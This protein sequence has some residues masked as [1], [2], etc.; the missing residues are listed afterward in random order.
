MWKFI[1]FE[2]KYWIKRP[3]VWIFLVI[4]TLL[5]FFA[6]ASEN[7]TIGGGIGNIY[8][9]APYVIQQYYMVLSIIC[10]LMTTSFMNATANRD[11]QYGMYQFV[12]SSPIKKRDY[13]FGK[14]FGAA[15][16]A[17]IPLLGVSLG[18]ILGSIFA[19]IF[20]MTPAER[21]G[22]ISWAG[23][24][25]GIVNFGLPNII[26]SGVLLFSLAIIYRNTIISFIGSMLILVF[27]IVSGIFTEDIKKEWLANILDP[28]GGRP[29]ST[30]TKYLTV[31]EKNLIA[32]PLQGDLLINR[33][34]WLAIML[35]ILY[36]VYLK[37]SFSTKKES[38][39][40]VKKVKQSAP[41]IVSNQVFQ[42]TKSGVFSF[43]TLI[44][45]IKF[46]L[47]AIIKNPTFIIIVAIGMILL[48]TNLTSFSSGYGVV[49]YPVTYQVIDII[50][51][52]FALFMVG[53]IIFYT[54]VLVW[55]ERDAKINEIQDATPIQTISLFS[56][57]VIA[58]IISMAIVLLVTIIVSVIAQTLHGYYRYELDVYAKSLLVIKLL[59]YTYLVILSLLF[60]YLIN[61]RYIAYFAVVAFLIVN[62]FIWG[63]LEFDSNM[64][65]FNAKPDITYSDMNGFG[66]FVPST[67]W[68]TLY[69]GLFCL[70]LFFVILLF[71]VRGKETH[72]KQRLHFAK[73]EFLKNKS[74]L[75]LSV[76][77]F[78]VCGGFVY[79]NTKVLNTFDSAQEQEDA[80]VNYELKYKKYE[81][82]AQPRFYKLDYNL[83]I[84]PEE[85][86][87]K[88]KVTAWARNLSGKPISELHFT[89][90]QDSITISIP[91][92]KLK[93]ND[94]DHSYRIYSLSKPLLANDSIKIIINT[95]LVSK[96]FENEVS[97][98]QLTQNGTFFNNSDIMPTFGYNAAY[99]IGDKNLRKKRKLPVRER[100]EKLDENN[101]KA[102]TNTYISNDSDWVE[103]NTIIST[104]S[105]QTAIAPGSLLKKWT[106]NG[107]NYFNY[108][109]D[110]K[111]FNFYSFISAK[112]KVARKKWKGIDLEVYYDE[113]HA[114]NVP[115]MMKSMQKALEYYTKNFG[116]YYH[117]QCR[118]IEF[119]RYGSFAQAFP[120]TMPYSEGIGFI[121]DLRDVTKDDIDMVFYVVAHEM[122]HQYWAHQICGANMQGS[123]MMSEGFAQYA[124]LMVMEKEYGKDKMKKFLEYEMN[125]Y[126]VGR[127]NEFEGE[128]ALMKTEH[129]GY[130]HYNK[131]SVVLYYFKEMIGEQNVNKAMNNLI[132]KFAYKNPP[133]PTS[134]DAVREFKAVTPDSLQYLVSDLF[135]NITL[136][137]NRTMS[138]KYK[139]IGAEYEVKITTSSEKF[140]STALGKETSQPLAD[141]I[142]IGVFSESD[143]DQNLG[144][145]LVYKRIKITKKDNI[146]TFRAKEKPS[147]A[148]IDPYNY[149]VDRIPDDNIKSTEE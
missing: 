60:H 105:D 47:K 122:G 59:G 92:A 123:E 111:S 147:K 64:L 73:T 86:G 107:R 53:F 98:T 5:V 7:V 51:S 100:M 110:Q 89:L 74:A 29:F 81:N 23:H 126:L 80:Q 136:F 113:K 143:N 129:Q 10:L 144:K 21:F 27:Y 137:S 52:S 44:S 67:I 50:D 19:P 30:M 118:I 95:K 119:P 132:T 24:L 40:K 78:V 112:Y 36:V 55:K 12:F 58:I 33:L 4:N 63:L 37:F 114:V 135:E 56:S 13:F 54:G 125:K 148:G 85:R 46:E 76:L 69:W 115:N 97:F 22:D 16:V 84:M 94:V 14:F 2:L 1:Q 146:F 83:D 48:I 79:Y 116:P 120:G 72:F 145:P 133:Y 42:P 66:P 139:K 140:R 121:T 62:S 124:A 117:K 43:S 20:D 31:D 8:K 6:T 75:L 57:K 93:L 17:V 49:Q 101:L 61:N 68:F 82:L 130:I 90:P 25:Y 109:L 103:V 26:I 35:I 3:M 141:Y 102:R 134:I 65:R 71:Y 104:S 108:K 87:L 127:S 34:V 99:E 88:A 96:G 11:F 28:F 142:D 9:N 131:A 39:K 38:V 45:L 91:N 32:T 18:V 41:A 70:I 138:V 106:A 128:N 149:L 15:L 77:A